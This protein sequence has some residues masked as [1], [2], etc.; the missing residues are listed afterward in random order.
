MLSTACGVD[1]IDQA[2]RWSKQEKKKIHLPRP[3]IVQMYNAHMGG[4]DRF[5]QN[6][7]QYHSNIGGMKWW[8]NLFVWCIECAMQNAWLLHQETGDMDADIADEADHETMPSLEF[9]RYV[10]KSYLQMY[11]T[12]LNKRGPKSPKPA[13][14]RVT[15]AVRFDRVDHW[16]VEANGSP[17]CAQC[18]KHTTKI[19]E[20]CNIG[21]HEKCFKQF[22]VK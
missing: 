22:H 19:C 11:A 4:V 9:R 15:N 3:Y 2:E 16:I 18:G 21:L 12:P 10:A 14:K 20:K 7:L 13:V 1:P 8:W 17:R 6:L 5:D